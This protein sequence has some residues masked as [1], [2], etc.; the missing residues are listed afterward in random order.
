MVRHHPWHPIK[1]TVVPWDPTPQHFLQS[2]TYE[3]I[4]VDHV[5]DGSGKM[6]G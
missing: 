6:S 1:A 2:I 5:V 4:K 3:T